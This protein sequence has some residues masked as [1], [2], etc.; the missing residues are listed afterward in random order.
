MQL[1]IIGLGRMGGNIARRLMRGDHEVVAYDRDQSIASALIEDG[2]TQ[3]DSLIDLIDKLAAPRVVWV[4]LP[5]GDPTEET[6][7]A[8]AERLAP[9]DIIID[10]SLIHI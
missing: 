8:L 6:I 3:A 9:G 7:Q 1:G 5:A 4:M 10:L 2:A